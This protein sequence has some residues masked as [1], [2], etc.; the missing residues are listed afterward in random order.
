MVVPKAPDDLAPSAAEDGGGVCVAGASSA[1]AVVDVGRPGVV[2]AAC[3]RERVE[4]VAETV[5]ACPS[6][7]GV[8]GFAGLDRDGGLAGVG[9]Q[10]AVGGVALAAIA[11][12][13]EHRRGAQP[14]VRGDEQRAESPPIRV[15]LERVTDLDCQLA[16]PSN[17][18]LQG[19]HERQDDLP[20]SDQLELAGAS[21]CPASQTVEQFSGGLAAGVAVTLQKRR[22][23]LLTEAAGIDRVGYLRR[24]ASAIWESTLENTLPAPGQRHASWSRNWLASPTLVRTRTLACPGHLP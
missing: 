15:G 4:R 3:V 14:G 5:V 8:F 11:D 12:L 10:G 20:A 19:G 21:L 16:D 13:G 24:N 9:G 22:E 18:R 17:D 7:L 1:G 2:A 23:P 6:E